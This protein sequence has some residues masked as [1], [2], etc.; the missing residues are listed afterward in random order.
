MTENESAD[1]TQPTQAPKR[2]LWW[3]GGGA[4]G[5]LIVAFAVAALTGVFSPEPEP[6]PV[7][8][9]PVATVEEQPDPEPEPE[10]VV[11]PDPTLAITDVKEM[12]YTPIWRPADEGENYWQIVD[13]EHGYV[14]DGGTE[15]LLAHTC[16]NRACAGDELRKLDEGDTLEYEGGLYLVEKKWPI[17]KD[18]IAAQ[19][20]WNHVPGRLV[21][22]T[23]IIETTWDA[24]DKNEIFIATRV[25]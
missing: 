17:M 16:E 10:P 20:L 21:I 7:T 3:I 5:L 4:V 2:K 24:S 22:I 8:P 15:Y 19:D 9:P 11:Y 1:N 14:S 12:P 13:P 23:C 25:Q 18:D 6:A